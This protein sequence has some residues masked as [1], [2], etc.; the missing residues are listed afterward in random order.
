MTHATHSASPGPAAAMLS[1]PALTHLLATRQT[2]RETI[3]L[4]AQYVSALYDYFR[5]LTPEERAQR[6]GECSYEPGQIIMHED[7]T[8]DYAFLIWGLSPLYY[9]AVGIAPATEVLA[10]RVVWSVLF[11]LILIAFSGRL[12]DLLRVFHN[13]R[14]LTTLSLSALLVSV[15]WLAFIWGVNNERALEASMG[16]FIFPIVMVALGRV[17]LEERLSGYQTVA[18]LLVVLGV[19]NLLLRQ[20]QLPWLALLLALSMGLYS[21]VRKRAPVDALLGLTVECLLLCPLAAGYLYYLAESG[22]L[23]F[24][25]RGGGFDLL[26]AAAA[27]MTALP[28]ILYTSATRLLRLGTVGL[29]QYIN[30]TCQFLLALFVFNEPFGRPY[31]YTF[32]LIWS[33]LLIFTLDSHR[34]L[35]RQNGAQTAP[36]PRDSRPGNRSAADQGRT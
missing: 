31:L 18:L 15:N 30:P 9:R 10:H 22:D 1:E 34:R 21:L 32:L 13:G 16:Y 20:Q 2:M 7:T 14:L 28:L 6:A 29:L 8:G 11:T 36:A 26:L 33:G 24:G 25:T 3:D 35:R 19:L 4:P 12:G 5:A 17:F 27:L 23:V